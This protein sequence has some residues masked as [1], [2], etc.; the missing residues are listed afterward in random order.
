MTTRATIRSR[1]RGGRAGF[2]AVLPGQSAAVAPALAT[3][4]GI[5]SYRARQLLSRPA[6]AAVM[7]L[8]DADEARAAVAR[9]VL[10]GVRCVAFGQEDLDA[11]PDARPVAIAIVP[12]T[13]VAANPYRAA[14]SASLELQLDDGIEA[15]PL[16][17]LELVVVGRLVRSRHTRRSKSSPTRTRGAGAR[18]GSN[19]CG[20][21]AR[22]W[23][24]TC[25][26]AR[27]SV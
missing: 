13:P 20:K 14:P 4:L 1:T 17:R 24:F 27:R 6:A 10:G 3:A 23:I 18:L 19:G 2:V 5:D 25:A 21:G 16:E 15:V 7:R 9:A 12:G 22:S 8:A 11:V 26:V